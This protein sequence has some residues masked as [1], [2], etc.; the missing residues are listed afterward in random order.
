MDSSAAG[1]RGAAQQSDGGSAP[2][3]SNEPVFTLSPSQG[4]VVRR[5]RSDAVVLGV[6]AVLA[7]AML[8]GCSPDGDV[9]DADYAQVCQDRTTQQRVEDEKCSEE[10]R[11]S[12]H[13]GWYFFPMG[14]KD[15]NTSRSIP[16]VGRTLTGGATSIPSG[17]TSKAGVPADGSSSVT[18]GG[19]GSSV[20]GG[21]GS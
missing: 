14:S 11:S 12:G 17:A 7:S 16:G 5:R 8:A 4:R 21:S 6:T 19:F 15:S 10:G 2:Q 1:R 3:G 13:F 20:K 18:R 9:I